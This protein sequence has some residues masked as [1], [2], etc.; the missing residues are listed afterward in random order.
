MSTPAPKR[1]KA[2]ALSNMLFALVLIAAAVVAYLYFFDD[3]FFNEGPRDPACETGR[4]ELVCVN[5]A[6][7]EA[8]LDDAHLGRYTATANQLTPPGQVIEV[9]DINVFLFVYSA[10]SDNHDDAVAAREADAENLNMDT[11]E[12]T[13]RTAER[14]L[15][16]E[17]EIH[18]YQ[19][20]NVILIVVG[21]SDDQLEKIEQAIESLP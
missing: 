16:E 21:G 11:L 6:L 2:V 3:R 8:G 5:N 13:S 14:P 12:I 19:H 10:P 15:S 7:V 20:S 4:N 17:G 9:D 1:S 18:V